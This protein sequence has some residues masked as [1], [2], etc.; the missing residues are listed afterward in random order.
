V[1]KYDSKNMA[2]SRGYQAEILDAE[3]YHSLAL[4]FIAQ[5]FDPITHAI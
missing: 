4:Y 5:N 3:L 2:F 1:H